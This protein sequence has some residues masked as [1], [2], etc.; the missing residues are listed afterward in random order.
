MNSD[1]NVLATHVESYLPSLV[2]WFGVN[3]DRRRGHIWLEV[4]TVTSVLK[5]KKQTRNCQQ[6]LR[7]W[8]SNYRLKGR[9]QHQDRNKHCQLSCAVFGTVLQSGAP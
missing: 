7:K 6:Q 4:E 8:S 1:M 9:G 5:T 2:Q 3:S